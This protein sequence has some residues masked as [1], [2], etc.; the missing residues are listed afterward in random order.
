[1]GK[2]AMHRRL[3]RLRYLARLAVEE[4]KRFDHE[5]EKRLSSWMEQIRRDAGRLQDP[6][7][8][9][10]PPVFE[11]VEEAMMVLQHCGKQTYER[12]APEA[13]ELLTAECCQAF[14]QRVDPRFFRLT[15]PHFF[16]RPA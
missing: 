1:M 11:R 8:G 7:S 9:P 16:E 12:Y 14:S 10:V 2:A 4:P 5:W 15:N 13:W 3:K 6:N